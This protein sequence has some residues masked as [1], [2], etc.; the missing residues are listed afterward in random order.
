MNSWNC[1]PSHAVGPA[2]EMSRKSPG[3]VFIGRASTRGGLNVLWYRI[4]ARDS[5]AELYE[6]MIVDSIEFHLIEIRYVTDE[7]LRVRH[8][9]RGGDEIV[10]EGHAGAAVW[11]LTGLA[12]R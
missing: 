1:V 7:G 12:G 10:A 9:A 6:S 2:N 4:P 5:L 8:M 3:S 11:H